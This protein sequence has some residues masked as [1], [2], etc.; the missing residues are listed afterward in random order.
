MLSSDAA[1]GRYATPTPRPSE[2]EPSTSKPTT[3]EQQSDEDDAGEGVLISNDEAVR[4]DALEMSKQSSLSEAEALAAVKNQPAMEHLIAEVRALASDR[5]AGAWIE[6][7]SNRV[8]IRVTGDQADT[9][10]E[11]AARSVSFPVVIHTGAT[12]TLAEKLQA[13]Q[14]PALRAWART[15]GS[16]DGISVDEKSDS[17]TFH[18]ISD[19]VT[20]PPAIENVLSERGLTYKLKVSLPAADN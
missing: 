20:V 13:A 16:V 12:S 4:Q 1:P 18:V 5:L 15:A 2:P 19:T 6:T 7:A 10:I 17:L 9:R 11:Q 14:D 3:P 8:V